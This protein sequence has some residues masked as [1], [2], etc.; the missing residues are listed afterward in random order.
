MAYKAAPKPTREIAREL[1]L[2]AVLEATVF[3]SG[4]V[5][6]INLQFSDPATT[7][8]LWSE[9]YERNVKD[10]LAAQNEIVTLTAAAVA[11][12]LEGAAQ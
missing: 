7:R 3:R 10:V 9:T 2:D 4:E 11:K 1:D 5:M 12:V 6:R 8:S